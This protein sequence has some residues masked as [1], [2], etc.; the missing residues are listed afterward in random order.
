MKEMKEKITKKGNLT[1]L[2]EK[3]LFPF[4]KCLYL[5][6]K[7]VYKVDRKHAFLNATIATKKTLFW[8]QY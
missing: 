3:P 5:A 7:K 4:E 1:N 2:I 8:L 6:Y